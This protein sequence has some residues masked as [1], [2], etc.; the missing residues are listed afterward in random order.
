M[1]FRCCHF[2]RTFQKDLER[3]GL[4]VD[5][6][7]SFITT[8]RNAYYDAFVRWQ[9]NTLKKRDRIRFGMR[10]AVFSRIENQPCADHD[11]ATGEGASP[12]EYT[13]IKVK[14][15]TVPLKWLSSVPELADKNIFLVAATLRP[16]TLY[17]QTNC[18]ILP[19]GEYGMFVAF[20]TPL[21][22]LDLSDDAGVLQRVMDRTDAIRSL[23][24]VFIC[25]QRSAENMGF[26][27]IVPLDADSEMH[28]RFKHPICLT[29][30]KG[31]EL[32]GLSLS[33]PNAIHET[34][35]TLP[36]MGISMEKGLS[37]ASEMGKM[38]MM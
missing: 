34:I 8:D 11:R 25:S 14:L 35:Y 38:K 3:F 28:H 7:R 32:L 20:D 31:I 13:L 36:M 4:A 22:S 17:G 27:G 2:C 26:Q 23:S 15:Q 33:A 5:W 16:E 1:V 21:N 24:T 30:L 6:R 19:D 10:P 18:F 9:F 37:M 12:Q 29:K